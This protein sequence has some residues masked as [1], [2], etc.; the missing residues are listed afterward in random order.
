MAHGGKVFTGPYFF[1]TELKF[2]DFCT[3]MELSN[4]I[5]SFQEHHLS[6]LKTKVGDAE[7]E[8]LLDR[9]QLS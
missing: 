8:F 9:Q 4:Y 2:R 5:A 3:T 1:S 7:P 6:L